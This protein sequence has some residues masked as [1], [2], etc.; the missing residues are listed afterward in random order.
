MASNLIAGFKNTKTK[1]QNP[2]QFA[3][4]KKITKGCCPC[5]SM[6]HPFCV[7]PET[8][9]EAFTEIESRGRQMKL[10]APSFSE[11]HTI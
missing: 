3:K 11:A 9:T 8:P 4:A 2:E 10:L 5:F 1:Q 6:F 7:F